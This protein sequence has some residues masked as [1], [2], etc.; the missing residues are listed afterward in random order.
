MSP[1]EP[2]RGV[3]III[4]GV[5]LEE[6]LIVIDVMKIECN[7]PSHDQR[8]YMYWVVQVCYQWPLG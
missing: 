6:G 8:R 7:L 5:N 4:S 2:E 3:I 1:M